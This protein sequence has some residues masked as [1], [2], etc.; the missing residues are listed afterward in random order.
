[1]E[2]GLNLSLW[3][4][5]GEMGQMST[6]HKNIGFESTDKKKSCIFQKGPFKNLI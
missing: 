1:M 3:P 4:Q 5:N 2:M 6:D